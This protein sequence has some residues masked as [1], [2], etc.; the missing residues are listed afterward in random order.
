MKRENPFLSV[1]PC[2]QSVDTLTRQVWRGLS[3]HSHLLTGYSQQSVDPP[4]LARVVNTS[5]LL[6]GG[7]VKNTFFHAVEVLRKVQ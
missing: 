5:T 2:K 3:T 4:G 1:S 7:N 6:F